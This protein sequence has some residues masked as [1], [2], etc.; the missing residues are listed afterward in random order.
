MT[1]KD[2]LVLLKFSTAYHLLN[3]LAYLEFLSRDGIRP[4]LVA[5]YDD[6]WRRNNIDQI[7]LD[8]LVESGARLVGKE[9]FYSIERE[10]AREGVD[11]TKLQINDGYRLPFSK[12]KIVA[13]DDGVGAYQ[14]VLVKL[15]ALIKELKVVNSSVAEGFKIGLSIL[16]KKVLAWIMPVQRFGLFSQL[17]PLKEN[18]DY[19]ECAKVV[20][21]KF[22]DKR[23]FS[24]SLYGGEHA[25]VLFLTQPAVQLKWLTE[26]QYKTVI[27]DL[28]TWAEFEK[29]AKLYIKRHPVDDFDYGGLPCVEFQGMAE[30]MF[31]DEKV[32]AVV[33]INS[34][35][36]I[37]AGALFGIPAFAIGVTDYVGKSK[38]L[39]RIFKKYT[40]LIPGSSYVG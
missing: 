29:G 22:K 17:D 4:V 32:V 9:E 30:E 28:R 25:V 7:Y 19:I 37:M 27:E 40:G 2:G 14:G 36:L 18:R 3:G 13:I 21:G 8:F 35:S 39:S 26:E 31:F 15:R 23:D 38:L 12:K 10:L 34:T 33:S 16:I 20:L 5:C 1:N 6:Y 11:Y 24:L